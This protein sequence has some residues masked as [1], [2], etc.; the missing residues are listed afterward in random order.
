[1]D[2]QGVVAKFVHVPSDFITPIKP[3]LSGTPDWFNDDE[4]RR[5]IDPFVN[6]PMDRMLK[7]YEHRP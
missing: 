5:C 4:K 3:E 1:M 7:A 2:L 6:E